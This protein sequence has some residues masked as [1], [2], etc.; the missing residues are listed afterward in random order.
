MEMDKL[1]IARSAH[2]ALAQ[3]EP[4]LVHMIP[5]ILE[6]KKIVNQGT[7]HTKDA[8][9]HTLKV[10]EQAPKDPDLRWSAL[11]HDLGKPV[12]FSEKDGEVH[13]LRHEEVGA[14]IWKD[15]AKRFKFSSEREEKIRNLILMHM[16]P[17]L[18]SEDWSDTSVRKLRR[19]LG[20]LLPDLLAL[21][22]ADISSTSMRRETSLANIQKL[23]NRLRQV[24]EEL[25][26]KE[27]LPSGTGDLIKEILG[28]EGREV[29]C[30]RKELEE[31]VLTGWDPTLQ[32]ILIELEERKMS[33]PPTEE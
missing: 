22:R 13:F 2:K 27:L 26:K 14:E 6:L 7:W 8:W 23:E 11:C 24:P 30:V 20:V 31:K 15:I 21:S 19:E 32:N 1:L 29:G 9:L 28:L 5:E 12:T 3:M 10:V 18:Y 33:H 17:V 4:L 25:T 16:R